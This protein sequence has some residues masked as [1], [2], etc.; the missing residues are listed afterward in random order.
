MITGPWTIEESRESGRDRGWSHANFT[1]A[2]G[3]EGETRSLDQVKADLRP[4]GM[5]CQPCV[6]AFDDG[7][8]AGIAEYEIEQEDDDGRD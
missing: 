1:A 2:Y 6:W 4:G 8:D 3:Q 7:F 5:T